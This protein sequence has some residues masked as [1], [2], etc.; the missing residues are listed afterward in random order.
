MFFAGLAIWVVIGVVGGLLVRLLFRTM[1]T[2]AALTLVFGV[3]GALIGGMLG[4]SAHVH[5]DPNPLRVGGL[6]G[7][8][9]GAL[10]FPWMYHFVQRK[11]V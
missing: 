4:S 9:T 11:T 3:F 7:A 2:Y 6:I 5:H 1:G 8:T 10:L